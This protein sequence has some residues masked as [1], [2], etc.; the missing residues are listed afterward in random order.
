MTEDFVKKYTKLILE[1]FFSEEGRIQHTGQSL[2]LEHQQIHEKDGD[3]VWTDGA[4]IREKD[5]R[6]IKEGKK[7]GFYSI[8]GASYIVFKKDGEKP[9]LHFAGK[10]EE[11]NLIEIQSPELV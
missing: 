3:K 4:F 2:T 1:E 11:L 8:Y 9:I 7:D 5:G 10:I 6:H